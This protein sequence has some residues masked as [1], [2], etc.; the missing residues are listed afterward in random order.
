[1]T[2]GDIEN[3]VVPLLPLRDV[4][5]FPSEVRVLYVGR[6]KSVSALTEATRTKSPDGVSLLL[7]CTQKNPKANDPAPEDLHSIG[8]IGQV[9]QVLPL[10]DGTLKLLVEGL[11]RARIVKFASDS[12]HL[13]CTYDIIAEPTEPPVELAALMR[14]VPALFKA[15][16]EFHKHI[17]PELVQQVT[18]I[19]SASR[20]ADTVVTHIPFRETA[21]KQAILEMESP[22]RRLE[23]LCEILQN[24]VDVLRAQRRLKTRLKKQ[25]ERTQR[26]HLLGE[27]VQAFERELGEKDEGKSELA[28][29]EEKL[30]SK[31]VSPEANT[32]LKKEF[33][34]LRMM[35]PISAEAT[36]V[37]N[38]IDWVLA[39]PWGTETKDATDLR[40]AQVLLDSDHYGL[41]KVKD[42]VL[43]YLAVQQLV[44]KVRGPILCFVGPPGVGKT[45]LGRSIA[46]ALGRKFV[47]VSLGGVRDEA[48]IRGHRRTYVGAMPGKILQSLKRAES[49]NP[50]MLLDEIDK[51]SSDFRG[52]PSAALLEVLDPEQNHSFAD[53]YLDLDY[54]LSNV[55]F[56]C[57]ANS[58]QTVPSALLD[59][60]EI[61][62]IAGYTEDEKLAIARK[63][64][65]PK[66]QEANGLKDAQIH[67]SKSALRAIIR[68]YTRESGVRALER[69][70][71]SVFRRVARNVVNASYATPEAVVIDSK[72]VQKLLGVPK[73]P[74]DAREKEN[75]VGLVNGLAWTT[76]G[77]EVL[78]TEAAVI[79]G[80]QRLI[81]T[82]MLRD[83]MKESAQAAVTWVRARTRTLG[84]EPNFFE[85]HDVHIH[86]PGPD[87]KDGPSAG[88]AMATALVSAVTGIPVRSDVAMTGEITLRGRVTAVGGLKEKCLAAHRMG[89]KTVLIPRENLKDLAE[90]PRRTRQALHIIPLDVVDDALREGLALSD[91]DGLRLPTAATTAAPP[92]A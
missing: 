16:A 9:V 29:L 35:G 36:V 76:H 5:L 50:V 83:L 80:K 13:R 8:T 90:I 75:Q 48:E 39:L 63:Y 74:K 86:F 26:V 23:K 21:S 2:L 4:V 34:K 44:G 6:E 52:D 3:T 88:V 53:H 59:R 89:L 72:A 31:S 7:L 22:A 57:T 67:F 62:R 18:A 91:G 58:M 56:V 38:Y 69:E 10:V 40:A 46:K 61:I 33:K 17:A 55:L 78:P 73:I 45:S 79:P 65:V 68:G 11:R 43:E 24:E 14:S 12:P 66:Q 42:R 54:D 15:F 37:R 81:V 82:G 87:P 84:I 27:K 41:S 28:E 92:E 49:N 70:L 25:M 19:E 51:L 60:L 32:K 77:G 30:K 47:R 20:L 64:L 85:T 1:M 71:A